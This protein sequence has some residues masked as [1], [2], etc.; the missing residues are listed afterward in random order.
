M[1]LDFDKRRPRDKKLP[2]I[3]QDNRRFLEQYDIDR[4]SAF[5]GG[6][7][8]IMTEKVLGE[9]AQKFGQVLNMKY[10]TKHCSNTPDGRFTHLLLSSYYITN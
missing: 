7:P 4:R 5:F 8:P 6:L 1:V 9:H 2:K 3:G 10:I